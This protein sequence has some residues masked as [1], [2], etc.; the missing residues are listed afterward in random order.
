MR[1]KIALIVLILFSYHV[2]ATL[3]AAETDN[4]F[5]YIACGDT[6][7]MGIEEAILRALEN[8]PMIVVQ[9]L[10][11][12]LAETFVN[13]QR[14][15]YDPELNLA[16][17]MSQTKQQRFLG[18]RPEPFDLVSDR[19]EYDIGIS[20]Q[21]PTGT[22]ISANASIVG[23]ESSIYKDQFFGSVSVTINQALLQGFG[24][25]TNLANLRKSKIDYDISAL[26]LRALAE[27]VAASVQQ[28]YWDLY[29]AQ[30]EIL[31]H[32]QSLAL[33][34]K[35]LDESMERV[36]V[37][38]LPELELA[39]VHAEVAIRQESLIDAQSRYEQARLHFISLMNPS[40]NTIWDQ[41]PV[42][43][44]TPFIPQNPLDSLCTHEKL[45]LTYRADL[46]Q[47]RLMVNRSDIDVVQTRN[48]LLPR[49][50]FFVT[51]G[52]TTYSTTLR[53]A[54]PD[55][56]SPFYEVNGGLSFALPVPNRDARA[57]ANRARI[58]KE[59]YEI[60][61][62]NLERLVRLDVRSAYVEVLRSKEQIEA[63]R[64]SYQ[65]QQKKLDAELEKFRVGRST[66]FLVL[67]AQRDVTASQLDEARAIVA[68]INALVNLQ[69]MEGTLLNRLGINI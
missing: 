14:A 64:V 12:E 47:A 61:V 51:L 68:Y 15:A 60:S 33:T 24:I 39:A 48:G 57:Q 17:S 2:P 21:L 11:P 67:Q 41:T 66:N 7:P 42:P 20:Q 25:G 36:Q 55:L 43:V 69:L 34:M 49:L 54:T 65:L 44:D 8:N 32:E 59:Q 9:R 19:S 26:E 63:T 22:S 4:P 37:G 6:V 40:D 29:L 58:S 62:Q 56:K 16:A 27:E 18:S 3:P 23:N 46:K 28:S 53:E 52:R 31:I 5:R 13:Q 38:R 10:Q 1:N 45:G 50:D 30:N 35:L